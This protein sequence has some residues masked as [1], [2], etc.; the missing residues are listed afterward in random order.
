MVKHHGLVKPLEGQA[1]GRLTV[2]ERDGSKRRLATWLCQ[3]ECGNRIVT[4]GANLR[5]GITRSCGCLQRDALSV[6]RKLTGNVKHGDYG[7]A[8]YR[9][10]RAI[11]ARC[12]NPN[13]EG[14]KD[15]GG[16]GISICAEWLASYETFLRDMGRRPNASM[17]IERRDNSKGYCKENCVWATDTEQARN[18]RRNHRITANGKTLCLSEWSEVTGLQAP[19]IRHRLKLGWTEE[20]A[21]TR[22]L[23]G[24]R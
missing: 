6:N 5:S 13:V 1:F 10:Y 2:V 14:F 16:R 8:E 23:R 11:I 24:S 22:P 20:E 12:T 9:I 17:S 15:Y 3:C 19:T 7:S 4:T 18:T 21:V